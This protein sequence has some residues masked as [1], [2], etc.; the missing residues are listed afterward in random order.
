MVA[1]SAAGDVAFLVARILFGGV[2]AFMGINHFGSVDAMAGYAEAKGLPAPRF[3]VL[4]S[5]VVLVLGGAGIVLG[6]FPVV[7]AGALAAFLLTTAVTM[8]D[9]WSAPE[10]QVQDEM[11]Q[12]LKNVALAGGALTLVAVGGQAWPYAIDVGLV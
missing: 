3:A 10:D 6:V 11:T 8:H 12:F 1:E 7:A 9:F 2:L 4:A 5:G